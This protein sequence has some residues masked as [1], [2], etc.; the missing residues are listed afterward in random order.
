MDSA[1]KAFQ[2]NKENGQYYHSVY[3]QINECPGFM[4]PIKL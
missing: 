1:M 3:R 4:Q 2:S